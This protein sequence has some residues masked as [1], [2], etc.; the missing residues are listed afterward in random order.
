M[1]LRIC[2]LFSVL[3]F[4]SCK[5]NDSLLSSKLP[6]KD[7]SPQSN[8]SLSKTNDLSKV[9]FE[10]QMLGYGSD[11]EGDPG[12][13][14]S[15]FRISHEYFFDSNCN[16]SSYLSNFT[17]FAIL[18]TS[19]DNNDLNPKFEKS[20]LQEVSYNT[21]SLTAK[22]DNKE[23]DIE[24]DGYFSDVFNFM[25]QE[26]QELNQILNNLDQERQQQIESLSPKQYITYLKEHGYNVTK[27][28]SQ[29]YAIVSYEGE[30]ITGEEEFMVKS[31]YNYNTGQYDKQETYLNNN[32]LYYKYDDK[33]NTSSNTANT[34]Y[35]NKKYPGRDAS[36]RITLTKNN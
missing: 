2:L 16:G 14:N 19:E 27:S 17:A 26:R 5:E 3:F 4:F 22:F 1:L 20:L 11:L 34:T 28:Q 31:Y 33:G 29:N 6:S 35:Y 21:G 13:L 18:S 15:K 23:E 9:D 30:T 32:K 12:N 7:L 25:K 10:I 8:F 24:V 36:L